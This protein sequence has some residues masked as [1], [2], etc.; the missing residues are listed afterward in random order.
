MKSQK[1]GTWLLG[2]YD[3]I[4]LILSNLD[5]VAKCFD[6]AFYFLISLGHRD[7]FSSLVVLR[8]CR[9]KLDSADSGILSTLILVVGNI[10]EMISFYFNLSLGFLIGWN[11]SCWQL[12]RCEMWRVFVVIYIAQ[13]SL[14]SLLLQILWLWGYF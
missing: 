13:C 14:N 3:S 4:E 7:P 9:V 5:L 6:R 2:H 10:G 8:F 12:C 1:A 11:S